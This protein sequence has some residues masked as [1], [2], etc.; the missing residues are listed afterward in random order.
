MLIFIHLPIRAIYYIASF[1]HQQVHRSRNR[2]VRKRKEHAIDHPEVL[3][4]NVSRSDRL[5]RESPPPAQNPYSSYPPPLPPPVNS[6]L[7]GASNLSRISTQASHISSMPSYAHIPPQHAPEESE[8][9][10][11][12]SHG[13]PIPTILPASTI[14]T[15]IRLLL[16]LQRVHLLQ[17]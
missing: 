3:L 5:G 14:T 6:R 13:I 4:T 8:Y 16:Y 7:V 1:A 15:P 10:R 11:T 9:V 17:W 12:S 2:D